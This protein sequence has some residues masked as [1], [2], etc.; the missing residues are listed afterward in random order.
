MYD[1]IVQVPTARNEPV[2]GYA[3][4]SGE[5]RALKAELARQTGDEIEIPVVI[6]GKRIHT[7]RT[8]PVVMPHRTRHVLARA[9]LAGEA[10][11]QAA[12]A[13]A[14]AARRGWE[15]TPWEAR[16]AVLLRAAELPVS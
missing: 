13:A 12:A 14:V 16:A 7:G 1:A 5:R 6:A 8:E 10:E 4:G 15:E 2:L 11:V 3:P 9:H